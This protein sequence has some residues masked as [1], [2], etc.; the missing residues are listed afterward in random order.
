MMMRIFAI[1]FA[2]IGFMPAFADDNAPG[3]ADRK[4][5]EE[6]SAEMN[7]PDI[8]D[9]TYAALQSQYRAS[10][11]KIVARR[12]SARGGNRT[13]KPETLEMKTMEVKVMPVPETE[14][15]PAPEPIVPIEHDP[16]LFAAGLCADGSRPNKFG[17]CPGERFK[18]LGNLE[19]ACCMA[20]GTTCFP[21]MK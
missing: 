21:P 9:E 20:D 10:C 16:A 17:C 6:I 15:A 13:G 18:D 1:L 8:D 5:C 2:L 11:I 19:F 7:D 3:V 14:P 12:N 4:T